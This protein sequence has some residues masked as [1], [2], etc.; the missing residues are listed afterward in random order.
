MSEIATQLG[1]DQT[2]YIQFVLIA[3]LYAFLTIVYFKPFQKLLEKRHKKTV[4]DRVESERVLAELKEKLN[5]YEAQMTLAQKKARGR[6][7][8]ILSDAKKKEAEILG[9][10]RNEAKNTTQ[11]AITALTQEKEKIRKSLEAEVESIATQAAT[12]LLL[13]QNP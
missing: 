3:I 2:F 10:A 12:K 5:E 9:A 6:M 1:L 11:A 8:E 7:D 4:S 13:R